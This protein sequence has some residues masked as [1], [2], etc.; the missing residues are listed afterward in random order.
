MAVSIGSL[1]VRGVIE[2]AP[3]DAASDEVEKLRRDLYRDLR[4]LRE[5]ITDA[6]AD[7]RRRRKER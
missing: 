6:I 4:R 5:E 3:D 1:T 2:S 7:D